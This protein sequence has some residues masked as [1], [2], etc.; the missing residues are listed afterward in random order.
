[1]NDLLERPLPGAIIGYLASGDPIILCTGASDD[2]DD[3]DDVGIDLDGGGADDEDDERDDEQDSDDEGEEKPKPATKKTESGIT[4]ADIDALREAQAKRNAEHRAEVRKLR[5]QLREIKTA[6]QKTDAGTDE[7]ATKAIE[8]AQ[9]AAERRY[10][11]IAIRNA[12]KAQFL[13]AGLNDL[14]DSRMRKLIRML[15]MDDIEVDE[16]GEVVGLDDQ[17]DAIKEDWPE[18]F[19]KPET[20]SVDNKPRIRAPKGDAADK[21]NAPVKPTTTGE[22]YAR[23]ILAG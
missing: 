1:M 21:K 16:D 3:G 10:K 18:L 19:R 5:A 8:E 11:P 20:E 12:A 14:S 6:G 7:A 15:D 4:Q 9:A 2:D 17:I 22:L 13:E 23:R